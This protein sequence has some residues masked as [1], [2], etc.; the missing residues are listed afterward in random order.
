MRGGTVKPPDVL[1]RERFRVM[2]R[3]ITVTRGTEHPDTFR[4]IWKDFEAHHETVKRWS[5]DARYYGVS[6]STGREGRIDYLAGMA[7][8]SVEEIPGGLVIREIPA[9]TY[10]VFACSVQTIGQTYGYIFGQWRSTA[11]SPI[12]DTRPAFEQYPAAGATSAP[13]LI[14]IPIREVKSK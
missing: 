3:V 10:A 5:T 1:H 6:F 8:N 14:H 11:G 2:G 4:S 13:V 9:A 7:V 12:E